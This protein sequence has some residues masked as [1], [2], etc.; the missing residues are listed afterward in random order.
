MIYIK[1]LIVGTLTL[2]LAIVVY[3]VIWGWL[4]SRKYA[5]L[6]AGGGMIALDISSLLYNPLFWLVAVSGFAVGFIW[7]FRGAGLSTN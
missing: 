4:M 5:S 6:T 1:S 7:A 2:L 3:S